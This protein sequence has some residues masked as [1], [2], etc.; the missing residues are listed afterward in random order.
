M[1]AAHATAVSAMFRD[2]C[3]CAASPT[4][5]TPSRMSSKVSCADKILASKG[6]LM[7]KM[8]EHLCA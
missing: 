8:Y 5:R 6:F 7:K 3:E 2:A 1:S 4:L